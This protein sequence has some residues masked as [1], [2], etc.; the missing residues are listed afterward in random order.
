MDSNTSDSNMS[1]PTSA[2]LSALACIPWIVLL[3]T[4]SLL[5]VIVNLLTIIVFATQR[6]R[7]RRHAYLLI[8]NLAIAD[9]LV[10]GISGSLQIEWN[11]GDSCDLWM[12]NRMTDSWFFVLKV[13][14]LH[15]FYMA[16]I[17]NIT[18]IALERMHAIICPSR[19]LLMKKLVYKVIIAVIWLIAILR[20]CAQIVIIKVTSPG[21]KTERLMNFTIYMSYFF[22]FSSY[23]LRMLYYYF[24]EDQ[25]Q[26]SATAST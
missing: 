7:H 1:Y 11:V 8:R 6:Q 19:H 14:L 17:S 10:G 9:L 5:I 26:L 18:A 24:H 13:S 22:Y 20:E 3:V 15:L 23:C 16:S 4:E 2:P 25:I 12:Y 21:R